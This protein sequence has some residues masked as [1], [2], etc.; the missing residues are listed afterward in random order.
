[1]A[2][3]P[4]PPTNL[5][6]RREFPSAAPLP[7]PPPPRYLGEIALCRFWSRIW[8]FGICSCLACVYRVMDARG[9]FG[10]H[11]K[12][13]RVARGAATLPTQLT[14]PGS[15]W[16]SNLCQLVVVDF[17]FYLKIS[18]GKLLKRILAVASLSCGLK[19]CWPL[20]RVLKHVLSVREP[21]QPLQVL[22]PVFSVR[23]WWRAFCDFVGSLCMFP[24]ARNREKSLSVQILTSNSILTSRC[25]HAQ[26]ISYRSSCLRKHG[27]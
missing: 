4:P 12:C 11:E 8:N 23:T 5:R 21:S 27:L 19:H 15:P 13:V 25:H 22:W 1:M 3:D 24:S 7:P 18:R 16:M 26:R 6:L 14:A 10:G 20:P 2:S 9:K 17:F